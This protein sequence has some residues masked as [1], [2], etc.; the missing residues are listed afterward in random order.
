MCNW[1]GEGETD[2][3]RITLDAALLV[4]LRLRPLLRLAQGLFLSPF[5]D[6]PTAC[7]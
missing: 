5:L 1:S 7:P 3:V 6:G 2:S 4:L